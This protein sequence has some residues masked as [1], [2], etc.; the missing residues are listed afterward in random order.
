MSSHAAF[1][2]IGLCAAALAACDAP[3]T[4]PCR[5][6]T[7]CSGRGPVAGVRTDCVV[8]GNGL[9]CRAIRFEQGY[10]PGPSRDVTTG[11]TWTSSNPLIA[12]FDKSTPGAL[13]VFAAGET[14][15]TAKYE[16]TGGN[17]M[18]V[19]VSPDSAPRQDTSI[20]ITIRRAGTLS[21]N[22]I[23]DAQVSIAPDGAASQQCVTDQNGRCTFRS[24]MTVG[25]S[26]D[27]AV[28][29]SGYAPARRQQVAISS[30]FGFTVELT[31][32]AE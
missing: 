14:Q 9:R 25:G 15:I 18:T 19:F 11:A 10:C 28:T 31:P 5:N 4:C 29:K 6:G 32:L 22:G 27:V 1:L 2:L 23:A 12:D 8:A 21:G 24:R 7:D 26:V 13:N 17:V 3:T 20:E 16:F 30:S